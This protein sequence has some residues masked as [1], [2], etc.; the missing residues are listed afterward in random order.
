MMIGRLCKM[1]MGEDLQVHLLYIIMIFETYP[2]GYI[3]DQQ[4]LRY[5]PAKIDD[6]GR[7]GKVGCVG[8]QG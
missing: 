8:G 2:A 6:V 5:F 4:L 1:R 7:M 3:P